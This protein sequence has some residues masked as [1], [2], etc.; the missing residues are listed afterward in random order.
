MCRM[1]CTSVVR[2]QQN[3]FFL[4][5][6]QYNKQLPWTRSR[7][8]RFFHLRSDPIFWHFLLLLL[9]LM[10]LLLLLMLLLLLLL[11]HILP[12]EFLWFPF[13][14]EINE[15]QWKQD[16]C[17]HTRFIGGRSIRRCLNTMPLAS[18]EGQDKCQ[19]NWTNKYVITIIAFYPIPAKLALKR[20]LK[21]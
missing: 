21:Y 4:W 10:F 5:W 15:S 7:L 14:T 11:F 2:K 12:W 8:W 9:L 19:Y 3:Q 1:I 17:C 6:G 20:L 13:M 18:S 16:Y